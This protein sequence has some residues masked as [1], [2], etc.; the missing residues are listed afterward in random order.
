MNE[1]NAE[2]LKRY[3]RHPMKGRIHQALA[4]AE[5]FGE[6]SSAITSNKDLSEQGRAK[7][8][9]AQL[10]ATLRDIRDAAE[11][12]GELRVKLQTLIAGIKLPA[13]DKMDLA[14]ALARQEI[15]AYVKSLSLADRAALLVG[16]KADP[17]FVDAVLELPAPL[18]GIDPS[19]YEKVRE[20][21]LEGLHAK[22]SAQAEQITREIEAASAAFA[23]A[24]QDV[25]RATS[26]PK[27][28]FEQ[29]AA[30]IESKKNAPWL[31][32][33]NVNGQDRIIVV[34]FEGGAS[35]L[36]TADERRDGKFYRDAAEYRADRA[37]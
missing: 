31:K 14:G 15:R 17:V 13:V 18:S 23:L 27:Q 35:R 28:E 6:R 12:L 25:A 2:F 21:R 16:D 4:A 1:R 36:A 22:E 33:D 34:P 9:Q 10:R 32:H 3:E 5:R 19:L 24:R 20:T 8:A 30:E 37:A 11:P 26:L 7:E 29:I